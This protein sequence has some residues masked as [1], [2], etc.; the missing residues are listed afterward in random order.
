MKTMKRKS[1]VLL[2]I[3]CLCIIFAQVTIH[4]LKTPASLADFVTGLGTSLLIGALV[5]ENINSNK[6]TGHCY[7]SKL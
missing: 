3:G 1:C 4:F 6:K 2:L 7:K 5:F